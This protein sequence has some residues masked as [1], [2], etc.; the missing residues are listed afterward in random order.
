MPSILS[1]N[2][3]F[4][5]ASKSVVSLLYLKLLAVIIISLFLEVTMPPLTPFIILPSSLICSSEMLKLNSSEDAELKKF[6]SRINKN[7]KIIDLF[8]IYSYYR[9]EIDY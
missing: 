5:S 7:N 3:T 9:D 2:S 4:P 6:K 8:F 1:T